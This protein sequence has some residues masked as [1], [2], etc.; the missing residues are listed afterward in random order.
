MLHAP[1]LRGA[2][3]VLIVIDVWGAGG[4]ARGLV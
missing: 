4:A 3:S 2:P 1:T